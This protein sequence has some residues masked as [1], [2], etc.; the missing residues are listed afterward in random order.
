[1]RKETKDWLKVEGKGDAGVVLEEVLR[2]SR[3]DC[4]AALELGQEMAE[5]MKAEMMVCIA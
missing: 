1:M 4:A 2:N 5:K 3:S